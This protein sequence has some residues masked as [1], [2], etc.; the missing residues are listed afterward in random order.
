[1]NSENQFTLPSRIL[2]AL[3]TGRSGTKYL[4]RLLGLCRNAAS[5]HEHSPAFDDQMRTAQNDPTLA[6]RFLIKDKLPV[7]EKYRDSSFY[8]DINHLWSKGL[9]Q[10]WLK[11][12]NLPLPSIIL[13]DH[14]FR[15][16]AKSFFQLRCIPTRT[17]S[18][19]RWTLNPEDPTC[20]TSVKNWKNWSD[21]Q[22][23]YWYVIETELVKTRLTAEVLARGGLVARISLEELATPPGFFRLI[24]TLKLPF[25][26]IA[27]IYTYFWIFRNRANR[28][29]YAKSSIGPKNQPVYE[30]EELE[31]LAQ[32]FNGE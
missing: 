4:S 15:K 16:V 23:C 1:M 5:F 28:Q 2:V 31:V 17:D 21:Y 24:R 18:G 13:L 12:P 6:E 25:P 19:N 32:C 26:K 29:A 30:K 20:L 10:A 27:N 3:T 11:Q 7:I 9:L 8:A 22:L 14:N